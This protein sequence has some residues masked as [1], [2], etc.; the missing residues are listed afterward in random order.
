VSDERIDYAALAQAESG[1]GYFGNVDANMQRRATAEPV[2][3]P[4]QRQ[5]PRRFDPYA[6]RRVVQFESS[7][8]EDKEAVQPWIDMVLQE[9]DYEGR[10]LDPLRSGAEKLVGVLKAHGM[11]GSAEIIEKSNR[12]PAPSP[13]QPVNSGPQFHH[14]DRDE[15][16]ARVARERGTAY[17]NVAGDTPRER[18]DNEYGRQ[19]ELNDLTSRIRYIDSQRPEDIAGMERSLRAWGM[20][21]SAAFLRNS[22]VFHDSGAAEAEPNKNWAVKK[23]PEPTIGTT[24]PLREQESAVRSQP[25]VAP[26]PRT[27][28]SASPAADQ[29][30]DASAGRPRR[31]VRQWLKEAF[32]SSTP[33]REESP[34]GRPDQ[35]PVRGGQERNTSRTGAA[36]PTPT[37]LRPQAQGWEATRRPAQDPPVVRPRDREQ[38]QN[39]LTDWGF[40]TRAARQI[41][42]VGPGTPGA[43]NGTTMP[44]AN[45][46]AARTGR[47]R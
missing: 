10:E 33:K 5:E 22:Y 36:H 3:V 37:D 28:R 42:G 45:A 32:G 26:D 29:V 30:R 34:R 18:Q 7:R 41:T 9:R 17:A 16:L 23:V 24:G 19:G 13:P 40:S 44:P 43:S 20:T 39:L 11:Y 2:P 4:P 14:W 31:G 1:M 35:S 46:P 21:N 12:M 8:A 47:T 15:F 38:V 6:F 25:P 27:A